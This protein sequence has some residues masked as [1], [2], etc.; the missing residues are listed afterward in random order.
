M[1]RISADIWDGDD[2][3]PRVAKQW[4]GDPEGRFIVAEC[5]GVVRGFGRLAMRTPTDGWLEGLRVDSSFRRHGVARVIA[6]R[7]LEEALDAGA[8]SLRFAT[9][10]DNIESIA[11][12]ESLGFVR[13][14]GFRHFYCDPQPLPAVIQAAQRHAGTAGIE[15]ERVHSPG[16]DDTFTL[17]IQGSIT[18]AGARG[19]L[20]SGFVFYPASAHFIAEMAQ[21]GC[22]FTAHDGNGRRAVLLMDTSS[23]MWP[24]AGEFVISVLE[25]DYS[26]CW[27]VLSH[28]FSEMSGQGMRSVS[29]C[30]PCG[31]MVAAMLTEIGFE[32]WHEDIPPDMP[33]VLL[34]EYLPELQRKIYSQ[35][36][37]KRNEP[38]PM[39]A[40]GFGH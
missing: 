9:S 15:A 24:E 19:M 38:V 4:V 36:H 23:E 34:Y 1:V 35:P 33:T 16:P 21:R 28:A 26:L 5:D 18:V 37:P 27:A 31:G 29:G 8:K 32:M 14:G 30:V 12:N 22:A 20:P 11:L 40:L 6:R 7:L 17:A 3:I 2:Y 10:C 39:G 13:I 25:G